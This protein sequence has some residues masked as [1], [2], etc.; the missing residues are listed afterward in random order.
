MSTNKRRVPISLPDSRFCG[1]LDAFETAP[2]LSLTSQR[3]EWTAVTVWY[4][5][6]CRP[7]EYTNSTRRQRENGQSDAPVADAR[8][9][10]VACPVV[11]PVESERF[12]RDG[13]PLAGDE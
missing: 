13:R 11:E 4:G 7:F 2:F 3:P 6:L 1:R 9:L 8:E 12:Q 10:E 5:Y